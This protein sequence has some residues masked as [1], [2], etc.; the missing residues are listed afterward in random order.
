MYL[1]N[2]H[3]EILEQQENDK[4][5]PPKG[6][7]CEAEGCDKVDNLWLN[8]TDGSILCGRKMFDGSGGNN[9]ALEHYAVVSKWFKNFV[10]LLI[11]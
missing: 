10:Y 3:S 4:K 5:V 9:H 6:W 11:D 7:R 1:F 8:L 2:R